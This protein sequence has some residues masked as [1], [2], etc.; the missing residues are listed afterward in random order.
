MNA[1][2][3]VIPILLI[4]YGLL[5]IFNKDALKRAAFFPPLSGREKIAFW[6]Y[7]ISN[8]LILFYPFFLRINT[9][10]VWFHAGLIIYILG[11]LLCIASIFNFSKPKENGINT[12][13]LYRFSRNPIYIAYFVYYLGCVLLTNSLVLFILL[14][15][16]QVSTHWI[17]LSE[18]RWCVEE[19]GEEYMEYMKKVRR[20]I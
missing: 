8:I 14:I 16:F 19:F 4:R 17:I 13:G 18:E 9:N 11:V 12:K 1:F 6:F 15:I 2:I 3:L 7:M 10:S 20:Y 5:S